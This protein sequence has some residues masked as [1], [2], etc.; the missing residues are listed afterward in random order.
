VILVHTG[1][2]EKERVKEEGREVDRTGLARDGEATSQGEWVQHI[3]MKRSA[4]GTE[5]EPSELARARRKP[6]WYALVD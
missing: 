2:G 1:G 3:L 6:T 4:R 5:A